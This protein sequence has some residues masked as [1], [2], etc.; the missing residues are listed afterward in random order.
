MFALTTLRPTSFLLR[1]DNTAAGK[2]K[3]SFE[4]DRMLNPMG[5]SVLSENMSRVH[6]SER[7]WMAHHGH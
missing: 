5:N 6:T 2:K 3:D 4:T 7:Q 1:Q